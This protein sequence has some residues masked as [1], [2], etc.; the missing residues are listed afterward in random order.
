[1]G[2]SIAF[3]V[4]HILKSESNF[5]GILIMLA[6]QPLI[7][8]TYLNLLIHEFEVGKS[9]I[10]A[11]LYKND[12]LGVPVLFDKFYIEE[13]SKFDDDKGAKALLHKYSNHVSA[14]NAKHIVSDID[15]IED[16]KRLYKANH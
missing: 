1:L 13:L 16:Y 3:G 10:I 7:D 9:Q 15:T 6:D 4:E 14:I 5:D 2:N 11:S 8:S 12:K